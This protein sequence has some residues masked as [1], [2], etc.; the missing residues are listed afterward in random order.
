VTTT[1]L[2]AT[3]IGIS[4]FVLAGFFAYFFLSGFIWGAGFEPTRKKEID[5]AAKL[6]RLHE[7][8]LVYDLGSGTGDVVIHIAK[9]YKVKCVGIE[10]DPL[11]SWISRLRISRSKELAGLVDIK[12]AN[13]LKIDLSKADAIYVFLSG[14]TRIMRK[15]EEKLSNEKLESNC[16]RI[17]SY[18]HAFPDL[19]E[20]SAAGD[21]RIYSIP[22]LKNSSA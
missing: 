9:K 6:L 21:I 17:A 7:G 20:E 22:D 12:R 2:A 13:F 8:M 15:L 18:I 4:L 3:I 5:T 19:K 10:I 14:G 1:Q 11:K 16:T